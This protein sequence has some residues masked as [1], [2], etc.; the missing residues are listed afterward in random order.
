M[1]KNMQELSMAEVRKLIKDTEDDE[2]KK[3]LESF[4]KKFSKIQGK[5]A[6][7]LRKE[8]ESL[9]ILKLKSEYIVKIIDTLPEDAADLNKIFSDVSLDED[10]TNKVLEIVKKYR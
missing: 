3:E 2:K 10:E 8:L 1:I 7:E 9:E 4:I 5:K 6:E